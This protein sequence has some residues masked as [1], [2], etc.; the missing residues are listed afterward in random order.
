[1]IQED[2][3]KDLFIQNVLIKYYYIADKNEVIKCI[4]GNHLCYYEVYTNKYPILM[5]KA[6]IY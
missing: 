5:Q 6:D 4:W 2:I 3:Y 1:M